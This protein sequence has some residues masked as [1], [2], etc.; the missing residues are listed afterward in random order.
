MDVVRRL[1]NHSAEEVRIQAAI[2][3]ATRHRGDGSLL[4][5]EA[6]L[7]ERFAVDKS[8]QVRLAVLQAAFALAD[9][10]ISAAARLLTR[11]PFVDSPKVAD[12]LCLYLD[13]EDSKLTW[14]VLNLEQQAAIFSQLRAMDDI[15]TPSVEEFLDK[16]SAQDPRAVLELMRKRVEDAEGGRDS[17][18]FHPMP[19][20]WHRPLALRE[21]PEFLTILRELLAWLGDGSSWRRQM[22]GKQIFTAAV[23]TFDDSVLSLL[24]ET[25][26][27]GGEAASGA[28]SVAVS[29]GPSTLVFDNV[30]FVCDVL[31]VAAR[32]GP[33]TLEKIRGA[34]HSSAVTGTRWGTP[35][36]PYAEDIRLRDECAVIAA[37]LPIGSPGKQFY[38]DLS[39]A[40]EGS[41]AAE[42]KD[43][44]P[45]DGR[46]W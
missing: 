32:L 43:D 2:G 14:D 10:D 40:G 33:V 29:S 13:W 44:R 7:L 25:L 36:Q 4:A 12:D 11:I 19:Y 15:G 3:L 30:E 41:V 27:T 1:L 26:R 18:G 46:E 28:V 16:R 45:D 9:S 6:A 34:L 17:K 21:H 39:E 42:I 22:H 38:L 20:A 5:G 31:D 8:V 35:G 23:G 37:Q 24:L